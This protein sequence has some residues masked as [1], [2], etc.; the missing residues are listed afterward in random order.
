MI[1][2][3]NFGIA[4]CI[5]MYTLSLATKAGWMV[6]GVAVPATAIQEAEPSISF[7]GESA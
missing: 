5:V 4:Q 2:L 7:P 1:F 6:N 3:Y